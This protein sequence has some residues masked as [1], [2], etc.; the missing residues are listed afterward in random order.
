MRHMARRSDPTSSHAAARDMFESGATARHTEVARSLVT[1]YPGQSYRRLFEIHKAQSQDRGQAIT[2]HEP[3][4]LMRRLN[5]VA[6]K[7]VSVVC[8]VTGRRVSSWW[9]R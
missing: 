7:G 9:P 2:F 8:P 3:A 1:Q 5:A 4:A 6:V